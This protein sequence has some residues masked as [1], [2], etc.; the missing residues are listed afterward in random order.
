MCIFIITLFL[1]IFALIVADI[2]NKKMIY[3]QNNLD[4]IIRFLTGELLR[5]IPYEFHLD[6]LKFY[7]NL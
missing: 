7:I 5:Q 2:K 4:E 3:Y 6:V 1:P